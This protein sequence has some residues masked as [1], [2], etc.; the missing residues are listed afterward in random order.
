MFIVGRVGLNEFLRDCMIL[1]VCRAFVICILGLGIVACSGDSDKLTARGGTMEKISVPLPAVAS[2][3]EGTEL[4]DIKTLERPEI[5]VAKLAG[6][7]KAEQGGEALFIALIPLQDEW[8]IERTYVYRDQPKATKR[9]QGKPTDFG[10][11][12]K[13]SRFAIQGTAEG[14]LVFETDSGIKEIQNTYWIHYRKDR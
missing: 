6:A 11:S 1:R 2:V 14:V 3:L 7:Y 8:I 10:L 5:D 4:V 13:E 9:Y 12:D